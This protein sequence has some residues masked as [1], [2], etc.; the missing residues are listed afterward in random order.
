MIGKTSK[1]YLYVIG[2]AVMWA[3]SGTAGKG[4]FLAGMTPFELVQLRVTL[5]SLVMALGMAILAPAQLKIRPRDAGYMLFLGGLVMAMVQ[6]TYFFAISKIQVVAAILI[7]YTAPVLVALYSVLFW[8]ERLTL[9]KALALALSL[10]GCYL[11]VGAYNVHL[12]HMNRIGIISAVCSAFAFAAY[13]LMGERMM[14]RYPP[15]TV[16]FYAMLFA[17]VT[18]N[19]VHPPLEFLRSSHTV[20]QWGLILY[21]VLFGTMA[22]FGLFFVG[23]NHIRSTRATITSTL[24]PISAGFIAFIFLGEALDPLQIFGAVLVIAAIV[25]LQIEREHSTLTPE[26]IRANTRHHESPEC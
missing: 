11:V 26:S 22:A 16:V 21:I 23:V 4:L 24:E 10:V 19:V 6:F 18:W 13:T 7:Q 17:S 5:A 8:G 25:L 9:Y 3:S 15:W 2:A 1:G 12:L 14:H 20:L